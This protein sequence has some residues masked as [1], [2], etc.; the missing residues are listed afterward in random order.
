[1][2]PVASPIHASRLS[3]M[4]ATML[5]LALAFAVGAASPAAAFVDDVAVE[6]STEGFEANGEG[7]IDSGT[8][9][10]AADDHDRH[11]DEA[12]P[13]GGVAAGFGGM[14]ADEGDLGAPHAMA[15][16]LLALVTVGLAAHRRR[17]AMGPA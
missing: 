3:F 8:A 14:A 12:A 1:M 16:G 4:A 15:A 9:Q 11:H 13:V 17:I 10:D 2:T 6:S 7:F 5:A